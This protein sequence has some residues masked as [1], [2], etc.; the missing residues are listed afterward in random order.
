MIINKYRIINSYLDWFTIHM[1]K[2]LLI[3]CLAS[4]ARVKLLLITCLA[5]QTRMKTG[6]PPIIFWV[7][8]YSHEQIYTQLEKYLT[9]FISNFYKI[10]H[11]GDFFISTTYL[12]MLNYCM[13]IQ[14]VAKFEQ[15]W[16]KEKI[17]IKF[18]SKIPMHFT[19]QL[20]H[21]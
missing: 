18:K 4:Q 3:T 10:G 8:W 1:W 2:F 21:W 9:F 11:F 12:K 7:N 6:Q 19:I 17:K 13:K 15:N 16:T 5:S 20:W 14:S